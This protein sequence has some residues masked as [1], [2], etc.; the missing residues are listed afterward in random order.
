MKRNQRSSDLGLYKDITVNQKKCLLIVCACVI[1]G[2]ALILT[3]AYILLFLSE[4][5]DVSTTDAQT[6]IVESIKEP[7]RP[8]EVNVVGAPPQEFT[9][10]TP[11]SPPT[12]K[13]SRQISPR[14]N[15]YK[16][17][18]YPRNIK[19]IISYLPNKPTKPE[20]G[21][22]YLIGEEESKSASTNFVSYASPGQLYSFKP[23]DISEV[24]LLA[25]D[26]VRFSPP[27]WKDFQ[28]FNKLPIPIH[29]YYINN[30]DRETVTRVPKLM[31]NGYQSQFINYPNLNPAFDRYVPNVDNQARPESGDIVAT[32]RKPLLV[33]INIAP[34]T[35]NDRY[36][37]NPYE[38][39][40]DE[41][42]NLQLKVYPDM[43]LF[44][45][46]R[47]GNPQKQNFVPY[48]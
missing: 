43:A 22:S 1:V 6:V 25:N 40:T 20:N 5:F 41:S 14:I 42:M 3:V 18:Q 26:H 7:G 10:V 19:E 28:K 47:K 37:K 32:V 2:S 15:Y 36:S 48:K 45:E 33:N 8:F 12:T 31:K 34:M 4:P 23:R 27:A 35:D 46:Y 44:P 21:I 13:K 38:P 11:T 30:S 17:H 9:T 24:N 16:Q 39:Y 29:Q